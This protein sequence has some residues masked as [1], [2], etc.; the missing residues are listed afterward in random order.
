MI[1]VKDTSHRRIISYMLMHGRVTL[2]EIRKPWIGGSAGDVRLREIRRKGFEIQHG[3]FT[4]PDGS[5]RKLTWYELKTP[6]EKINFDML[7]VIN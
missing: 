2:E 4:N 1:S 5:K 6:P 3:N 7:T